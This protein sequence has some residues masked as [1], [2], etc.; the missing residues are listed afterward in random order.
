[1][2][3][4]NR[5]IET[6]IKTEDSMKSEN[7]ELRNPQAEIPAK[8]S[9]SSPV[10]TSRRKF[11]EYLGGTTA[12]ALAAGAA[13]LLQAAAPDIQ[14]LAEP[15]SAGRLTRAEQAYQIR[16][17]SAL[18]EKNAPAAAHPVNGDEDRYPGKIASYS[19]GLPH[20]ELGEVH[21]DAYDTL[22]K[23]RK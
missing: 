23:S 12:A 13:P 22:Q 15:A 20:N 5:C 2:V 1:M 21:P 4:K 14:P 19:K 9:S 17:A 10:C 18:R 3:L 16:V 7:S 6:I 8:R 11:F